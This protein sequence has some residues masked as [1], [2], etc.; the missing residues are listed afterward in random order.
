MPYYLF[1]GSARA[2]QHLALHGVTRGEFEEV[3]MDPD[4]VEISSSS[5]DLI[6]FGPT[7]TGKYLACIYDEFEDWIY[8][9]TADEV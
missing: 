5:G 7:S 8:P 4:R 6:A 1:N 2:E 9:I 3:V